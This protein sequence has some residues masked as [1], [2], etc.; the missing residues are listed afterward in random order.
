MKF[1]YAPEAVLSTI[2]LAEAKEGP[3][4]DEGRTF[5]DIRTPVEIIATTSHI[6]VVGVDQFGDS[7]TPQCV[8][9]ALFFCTMI[10]RS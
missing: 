3:A 10:V 2:A 9:P 5:L 7:L 6:A 8:P 1:R 4:R